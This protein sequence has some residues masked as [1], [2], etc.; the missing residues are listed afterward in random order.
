ME[1]LFNNF[2]ISISILGGILLKLIGGWDMLILTLCILMVFDYVMGIT[3]GYF[4]KNL[5]S[6][7]GF[8]GIIKKFV[9]LIVIS[10]ANLISKNLGENVP[11]RE[12]V[13]TFFISNESI[14]IL[15]NASVFIPIPNKLKEALIQ[16]RNKDNM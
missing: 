1:K 3:R 11:L 5:D 10:T 9:I 12:I 4:Q 15:E 6:N 8:W 2:C 7:V 16:L 13:I 14:S